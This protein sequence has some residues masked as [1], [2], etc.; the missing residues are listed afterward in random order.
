MLKDV[1]LWAMCTIALFSTEHWI[2]GIVSLFVVANI[3]YTN[4]NSYKP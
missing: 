3:A 4:W 1:D 2:G